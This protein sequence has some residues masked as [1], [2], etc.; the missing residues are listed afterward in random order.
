SVPFSKGFMTKYNKGKFLLTSFYTQENINSSFN[1]LNG[2]NV[3]APVAPGWMLTAGR[4]AAGRRQYSTVARKVN[5]EL[6]IEF[7]NKYAFDCFFILIIK[8]KKHKLGESV[9]LNFS[10]NL[11][12]DNPQLLKSISMLLNCGEIIRVKDY[13]NFIVK[14]FISI[15]EIIIPFF[16]K[17]KLQ[18]KK[19]EDFNLWVRAAYLIKQKAHLTKEGLNDIK[20]IKL[21][22]HN[23]I[24]SEDTR[25]V[26]YGSNLSS[27]VGSPRFTYNERV[28][29][30]IPL[31]KRSV[32]I[33]ILLSD[34]NLHKINKGGDAR[35]QFKQKYGQFE[36]LYSVFFQL[37]HYCSRGPFVTKAI[38]HKKVHYG[39]SFTTRT[40]P[41]ITKLYNLFYFEGKKNCS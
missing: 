33:G 5:P 37:S 16:N 15:N 10:I 23:I 19:F 18:G 29:I 38:L 20:K 24:S 12:I 11:P 13:F 35:L 41:C 39:L 17:Y 6:I 26:L 28:L 36:Y 40:L 8:S 3:A 22:M 2:L 25:L 9:N 4:V 7:I 14:D 31:N 21:L 34:A 30:E 32:F 27:T 1:T